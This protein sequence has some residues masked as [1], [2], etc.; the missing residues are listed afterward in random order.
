MPQ[1]E[2][3]AKEAKFVVSFTFRYKLKMNV[4]NFSRLICVWEGDRHIYGVAS[5]IL[6]SFRL[7]SCFNAQ[8]GKPLGPIPLR[9]NFS[10]KKKRKG[11]KKTCKVRLV[12]LCGPCCAT[13]YKNSSEQNKLTCYPSLN[14]PYGEKYGL[15]I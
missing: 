12:P 15:L 14:T 8:L 5:N 10:E 3:V 2:T 1:R 13:S 7:P 9:R 11:K 4:T 6:Y